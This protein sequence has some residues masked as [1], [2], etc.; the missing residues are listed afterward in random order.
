MMACCHAQREA[1]VVWEQR[2]EWHLHEEDI[3]IFV[4]TQHAPAV[5]VFEGDTHISCMMLY[6]VN[7]CTFMLHLHVF[8][9]LLATY[10]VHSVPQGNSP[11]AKK[12]EF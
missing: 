6:F 4:C 2:G 10:P 5:K 8:E 9:S 11:M 12:A 1:S 3:Q 7:F